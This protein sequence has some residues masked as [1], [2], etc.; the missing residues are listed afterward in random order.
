[1]I[2]WVIFTSSLLQIKKKD[3]REKERK[4]EEETKE[5]KLQPTLGSGTLFVRGQWKMGRRNT[6]GTSSKCPC[7]EVFWYWWCVTRTMAHCLLKE[8]S[9]IRSVTVQWWPSTASVTSHKGALRCHFQ[10]TLLQEVG[11][12]SQTLYYHLKDAFV[13]DTLS[14]LSPPKR[15]HSDATSKLPPFGKL[16]CTVKP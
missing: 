8:M 1:M 6:S 4:E 13:L 12:Y 2:S 9:T 16:D 11:L 3:G 14:Y 7:R 5:R 10:A 15:G